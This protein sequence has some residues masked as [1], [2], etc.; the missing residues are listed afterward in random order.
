M[1]F[2]VSVGEDL[3]F[4]S[5]GGLEKSQVQRKHTKITVYSC[6]KQF[7]FRKKGEKQRYKTR[8]KSKMHNVSHCMHRVS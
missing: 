7:K 4:R 2:I 8:M 3:T 6:S 1:N 5:E